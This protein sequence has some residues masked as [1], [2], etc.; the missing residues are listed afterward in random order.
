MLPISNEADP[1]ESIWTRLTAKSVVTGTPAWW[2]TGWPV[3]PIHQL[4]ILNVPK[5]EPAPSHA[6]AFNKRGQA[7]HPDQTLLHFYVPDKALGTQASDPTRWVDHFAPYWGIVAPD[8]SIRMDDPVDM[9]MLAVRYSRTAAAYYQHRGLRVIPT[10]RWSGSQ[11]FDFCFRGLQRGTPVAFSNHGCQRNKILR[12]GFL[13]GLPKLLEVVEP[14]LVFL[15][16]SGTDEI[17]NRILRDTP[18][19][20]MLPDINRNKRKAA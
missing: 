6:T 17:A 4:P 7:P 12:Q 2:P 20:A 11:D 5:C 14:A 15:H 9:R 8:F 13:T 3:E 19:I 10:V 1:P 16:G 18:V